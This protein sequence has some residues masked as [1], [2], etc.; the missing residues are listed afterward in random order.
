[1]LSKI[2]DFYEDDDENPVAGLM[3]FIEPLLN[4]FLCAVIGTI[5]TSIKLPQYSLHT[6]IR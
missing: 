4:T 6:K 1:M 2:A 3:N 5:V